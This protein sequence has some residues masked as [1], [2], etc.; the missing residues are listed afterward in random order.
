MIYLLEKP[1]IKPIT[2]DPTGDKTRYMI[3]SEKIRS[4]GK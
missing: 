2:E 4:T 3:L 1:R